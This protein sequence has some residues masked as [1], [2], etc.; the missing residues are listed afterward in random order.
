TTLTGV[1]NN[2]ESQ[3]AVGACLSG[4]GPSVFGIFENTEKAMRAAKAL[5]NKYKNVFACETENFGI[6]FE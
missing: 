3:G 5:E 6:K 1:K 4:S 2:T